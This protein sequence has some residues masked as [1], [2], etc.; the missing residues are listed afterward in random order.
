MDIHRPIELREMHTYTHTNIV[1]GN[2][3]M[4]TDL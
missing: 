3:Y 2:A 1:K 4:Y